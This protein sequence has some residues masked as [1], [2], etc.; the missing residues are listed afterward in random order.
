LSS[1]LGAPTGLSEV[2]WI[3]TTVGG[4]NDL[5]GYVTDIIASILLGKLVHEA[6]RRGRMLVL[7]G[8]HASEEI[9][10]L[11]GNWQFPLGLSRW[12]QWPTMV[13]PTVA[14]QSHHH[15]ASLIPY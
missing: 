10:Q 13:T 14:S 11:R 12:R 3:R 2:R 15:A 5:G 9:G 7:H 4:P 8:Q 1:D 6:H